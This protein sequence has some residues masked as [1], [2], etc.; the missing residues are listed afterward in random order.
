M[1]VSEPRVMEPSDSDICFR[2]FS[3]IVYYK[4]L[5]RIPV[6]YSRPL[7]VIY[8]IYCCCSVAQLCP[9]LCDPMDCSRPGFPVLYHLSELAQTHVH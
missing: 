2:F 8:F 1:L 7:W 9:I 5:S 4:M 6:L 3:L